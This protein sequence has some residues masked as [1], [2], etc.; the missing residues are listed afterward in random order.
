M[1]GAA[2]WFT[3][4]DT[5]WLRAGRIDLILT[6]DMLSVADLRATLPAN[7]RT[8]PIVCYFHENQLTYPI[9][10]DQ[11]RDYQYGMTNITSC[12]AADA[13]WFNSRFHR[14][15]FLIAADALL[16]KMP[17]HVPSRSIAEISAKSSVHAPP[18]TA[19]LRLRQRQRDS[20]HVPTILWCHR[21]EFDKNPEPFFRACRRLDGEGVPFELVC[22]GEQFREAPDAFE[23]V[24]RKLAHRVRHAGHIP[25]RTRYLELLAT[26]DFVVSSA[27]QENFGIAVIEAILAGCQPI[28]PARLAYPEIIPS[29]YR[30]RCLYSQDDDLCAAMRSMLTGEIALPPDDLAALQRTLFERFSAE[31][32]VAAI[33]DALAEPASESG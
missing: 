15:E 29:A 1:R 14:D 13:V 7:M 25:D 32:A 10:P 17:D 33:D 3:G 18:I 24:H 20:D 26:C 2:I 11:H 9:P 12:L 21:W 22:L 5:Q 19:P 16:R 23:T 31:K 4:S 6:C 30:E 27:I 28:L 8:V